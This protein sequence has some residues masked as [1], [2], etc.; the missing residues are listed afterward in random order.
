MFCIDHPLL[1]LCFLASLRFVFLHPEHAL[2]EDP[3]KMK[4]GERKTNA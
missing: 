4:N 1:F 3:R 2:N